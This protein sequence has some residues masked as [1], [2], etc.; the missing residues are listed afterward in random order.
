MN[1]QDR[2]QKLK[3]QV[4][5]GGKGTPRRKKKVVHKTAGSDD[6]KLQTTLKK[7]G[8]NNIPGVEEVNMIKD[9]GTVIHFKNPKVQ[10][11]I[12]ASTFCISGK[13]ET[14]RITELMPDIINQLGQENM[15]I[16]QNL[17]AEMGARGG[18]TPSALDEIDGDDE[19]V[20]E[21]EGQ[22]FEAAAGKA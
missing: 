19:D 16:L 3:N 22:N 8:V 17:A 1:G 10:A 2:V 6:K 18:V 15:S 13:S 20:P 21:L 4:R 12:A 14:K 11:A 7:L 5:T 9:D